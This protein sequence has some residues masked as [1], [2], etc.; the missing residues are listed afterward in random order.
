MRKED[1]ITIEDLKDFMSEF[2]VKNPE[3]DCIDLLHEICKK[4]NWIYTSDSTLNYDDE[5]F[6][7]D[8][9]KILAFASEC[10]LVFDYEYIEVKYKEYNVRVREDFNHYYIDFNTG[11]GAGIYLKSDWTLEEALNDQY[12][13]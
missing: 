13:V 11:L 1:I 2:C 7:T 3:D 6:V 5:D 8:G 10:W 9:D 12:N 4:N